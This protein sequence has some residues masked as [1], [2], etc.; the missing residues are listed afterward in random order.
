MSSYRNSETRLPIM[1]GSPPALVPPR[2]DWD[3]PPW[4]RW[5][6]QNIRQILP[7]AEVWRGGR[8]ARELPR[9]EID[10]DGLSVDSTL[11]GATTLAGLLDE[12]Y[13][14]GFLVVRDGAIVYERYFNGMTPRT[15]HLSQSVAKSV[16]AAAAGAL[17]GKGLLDPS[18]SVTHYLPELNDTAYRGALLQH[19]LDMTSGVSFDEIYTDPY[20]DI[21]Q[22]DVSSGWKPIPP[23]SDPSF[24]WP[25]HV[26]E[27][28]LG[29][30]RLERRHGDLFS[31]R[32]IETEVLGFC[33]ERAAG[34]RLPQIVSDEIWAPMGAEESASF[35]VDAVGSAL[36]DGGFNATLRDYARL[37]LLYLEDGGGI[38]PPSWIEATRTGNHA[39]FG[40]PYTD[41]LPHGAYRNQWWI[42]DS[43]SR[44]IY[45]RGVFG[46]M[47]HVNWDYRM[48]AVKL[49]SWPDFLNTRFTT[50]TQKALHAIGRHLS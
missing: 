9:R 50:A 48:V 45:A 40:A 36:A 19:V 20:S 12:T 22:L 18:A 37:G 13:T 11:G 31:Y 23:G 29:L 24:R 27:Q 3:R 33:M 38:L 21:G 5:S 8:S 42:E 35:T 16:T 26:F 14:D 32:S 34:K 25:R 7:T 15:L 46:Q 1:Q 41:S 49:S 28:V 2:M 17:I 6:F 4:N 43:H 30:E 10:L 39:I 47:I 44:A